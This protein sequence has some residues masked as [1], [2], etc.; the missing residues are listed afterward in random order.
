MS[1]S[2]QRD[3]ALQIA[4]IEEHEELQI[5]LLTRRCK[6]VKAECA[7]RV[8]AVR[9]QCSARLALH[10]LRA[11]AA[12]AAVRRQH[13]RWKVALREGPLPPQ[14][15]WHEREEELEQQLL[16]ATERRQRSAI[17]FASRS[18]R[19]LA[20]SLL[21]R[22]FQALKLAGTARRRRAACDVWTTHS[23]A[24]HI[25]RLA[26]H[27]W[28]LATLAGG[29]LGQQRREL[30]TVV[31]ERL[32]SAEEHYSAL[33]DGARHRLLRAATRSM[34]RETLRTCWRALHGAVLAARQ[35]R[36]RRAWRELVRQLENHVA[37]LSAAVAAGGGGGGGGGGLGGGGMSAAD[38]A[39]LE[40]AAAA[41]E[42]AAMAME[43]GGATAGLVPYQSNASSRAAL[44]YAAPRPEQLKQQRQQ[45]HALLAAA[46]AALAAAPPP[47]QPP[48]PSSLG[49]TS[50]DTAPLDAR[51]YPS[52][53]STIA[54]TASPRSSLGPS[55]G[56][57]LGG[58]LMA[59]TLK[60][61]DSFG[62]FGAAFGVDGDEPWG[63]ADEAT[64]PTP[65]PA[66][67]ALH[68]TPTRVPDPGAFAHAEA[69][70][71][72][73]RERLAASRAA[74]V[75]AKDAAPAAP[76]LR[77]P[78]APPLRMGSVMSYVPAAAAA[79]RLPPP[80]PQTPSVPG[81]TGRGKW[82]WLELPAVDP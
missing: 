24:Q 66:E 59:S 33:R 38:A 60:S 34:R 44:L 9:Q 10:A 22:C 32:Q 79:E 21:W 12:E 78:Q 80:P 74:T 1:S 61:Q 27:G 16:L 58:S 73:S 37:T 57:P 81:G 46:E 36:E 70:L 20:R 7:G 25:R 63:W 65:A 82:F 5:E 11:N 62:G 68:A 55:S 4:E 30:R 49:L 8:F 48:L 53:E 43:R 77:A 3:L 15:V 13:A 41:V 28:R 56:P 54:A 23:Q 18:Q 72:R 71:S 47:L 42:A 6:A 75:A 31:A 50:F 35:R 26:F 76:S 40:A 2:P 52:P 29:T 45:Q 69:A 67:A 39:A 19:L 14:V 51:S 17:A 64:A